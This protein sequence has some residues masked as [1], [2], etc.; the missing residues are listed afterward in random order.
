M[1]TGLD[2]KLQEAAT[3]ALDDGLRR[4]DRRRGFRKPRRN[5][6]GGK[7][8]RS[9]PSKHPRWDRP[10]AVGDV[11]PAVVT[12]ADG[13][14]M[15]LRAGALHVVDRRRRVS[16]GP[17]RRPRR[18]WCTRAIWSRHGC[19]PS[20]TRRTRPP[21]RSSRRRSSKGR[22]SRSTIAPARSARSSAATTSIEASSIARS[23]PIG[24]SDPR[25]SR[26]STRRR[27]IEATRQRRSSWIRR[28]VF[29][30]R[31]DLRSTRR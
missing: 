21:A 25:S 20:T 23:R 3:R 18:S 30:V 31:P 26:S 11:V 29:R 27:S 22:C 2:V 13:A 9:T 17:A 8:K 1:Q 10:M 14:V 15:H 28:R 4:I 7:D 16:P 24:R 12:T 5:V 6:L 19:S